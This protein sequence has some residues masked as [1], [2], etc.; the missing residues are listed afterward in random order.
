MSCRRV[1]LKD[2]KVTAT[3]VD[4]PVEPI[5]EDVIIPPVVAPKPKPK[6][7]Y[8]TEK[9][10]KEGISKLIVRKLLSECDY[11][12][13][14]KKE[15]PML[16]DSIQEKIKYFNPAF[17][18]MTPEGLNSRLTFLNQCVRPGETIPVIGDKGQIVA[19]DA[20]NTSFGFHR[21]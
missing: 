11:F 14:V 8:R 16:Y 13:V 21:C 3:P 9:T 15:V 12:D 19:N 7:T 1:I 2:I 5:I 18:S 20:L 10:L 4:K 6:P 17:H